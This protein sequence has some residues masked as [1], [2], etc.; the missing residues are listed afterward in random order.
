M[1]QL[2]FRRALAAVLPW[3]WLLAVAPAS[4]QTKTNH[5]KV[6]E[7]RIERSISKEAVACV[8][9]HKEENPGIF[10]DWATSRHANANITCLDCHQAEPFD[11]D[12]SKE[13]FKQYERSGHPVGTKEYRVPVSAV[14]TPKDC[15]R[16]HPDEAQ[17]YSVSKHANTVEIM[18][19]IDPWLG[20]GLNSEIERT[21]GCSYCHGSVLQMKEGKLDPA[22]WPNVG[23][24]R[25]NLDASK[26]SCTSCHTRHRFSLM[27]ARKPEACGQCHLGP[28]HPQIEIYMESKHGGI[29]TAFGDQYHWDG[30]PGT[31]TAG[32]DYRGPTCASCHMSGA[33]SVMTTHDV[34]ERL[35]WE[36]Q[37]PL[38][39]RPADF[40]AFPAK[41]NWEVER[42]KMKEVCRQCHGN[43]WVDD[44]YTKLD[45]VIQEYNDVYFKPAKKVLDDLYV[46]GSLDKTR[47]FD[48]DLEFEYYELWHHEGRRARMG[49]AMMA[50]DYTWWH[51]FYECKKRYVR[52]MGEA[53]RLL[54]TGE[55]AHRT[56]DFPGATGTTARP[57][58]VFS[59]K[60]NSSSR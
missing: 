13:H 1:E 33:G 42:N 51:G 17:Q 32:V 46:K 22:G 25:I 43:A 3:F 15:S 36:L 2:I 9:C 49:A 52:F 56:E 50:P 8:E 4:A 18:W 6:K 58:E 35:S 59:P 12:V 14:V 30:A 34:T 37:A 54:Q 39:V 48:E 40:Q 55:K 10:I 57:P 16:C 60:A 38:T 21:S 31:W 45:R 47:M 28:D 7:F 41:T 11:P 26:G 29:Y 20:Q 44:H 24:G 27:E 53:K 23:V 19:K 5:P